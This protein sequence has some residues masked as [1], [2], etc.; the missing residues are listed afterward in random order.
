MYRIKVYLYGHLNFTI[1]RD[2][3]ADVWDETTKL[4]EKYDNMV[5]FIVEEVDDGRK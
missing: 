5:D 2:N 4:R 1:I 3:E